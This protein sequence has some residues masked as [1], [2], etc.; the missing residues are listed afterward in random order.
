MKLAEE[1]AA[2]PPQSLR[3]A[4][5]LLRHGQTASYETIMEMSAAAQSMM[6]HTEDHIEGVNAILEKR[7]GVFEG[8]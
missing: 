5:T 8:R 2:Q 6:H 3:V 4:K 1:M 7:K